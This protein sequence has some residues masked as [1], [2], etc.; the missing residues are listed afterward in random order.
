MV[1]EELSHGKGII[2]KTILWEKFIPLSWNIVDGLL[3]IK[4]T[5]KSHSQ[6]HSF[7]IN[8]SE[9]KIFLKHMK[10]E[11]DRNR[12]N[13]FGELL[14]TYTNRYSTIS[15]GGIPLFVSQAI[16]FLLREPPVEGIFRIE[17]SIKEVEALKA[18]YNNE[19]MTG[20]PSGTSVHHVAYLLKIFFRE[21][22]EPLIP[23]SPFY[24][25]LLN[26]NCDDEI[27][28]VINNL[29]MVL[30]QIPVENIKLL[31][32][33]CQFLLDFSS[34]KEKTKMDIH[35]LA[36]VFACNLLRSPLVSAQATA[37]NF[38]K[39]SRIIEILITHIDRILPKHTRCWID[40][41]V[42]LEKL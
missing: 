20:V 25:R 13:Q 29:S 32:F 3:E 24:D 38:N 35:N 34:F 12:S 10:M 21:L 41:D 5:L 27:S 4:Y 9:K 31:T 1:V 17:P 23:A 42:V 22:P 2:K 39:T 26:V 40:D 30:V 16:T 6:E 14:D 15:H 33:L 11:V 28:V 8:P 7:S 37:L 19:P 36:M 18:K